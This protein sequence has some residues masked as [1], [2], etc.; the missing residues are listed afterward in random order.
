MQLHI[1]PHKFEIDV[2]QETC[3]LPDCLI[4]PKMRGKRLHPGTGG[5]TMFFEPGIMYILFKQSNRCG[6]VPEQRYAARYH[7]HDGSPSRI[8]I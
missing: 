4:F 3:C 6:A 7:Q 1:P 8:C 2:G 5:K